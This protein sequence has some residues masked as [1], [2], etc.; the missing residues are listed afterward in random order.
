MLAC[1]AKADRYALLVGNQTYASTVGP[2]ENPINDINIVARSLEQIG[3]KSANIRKVENAD[4]VKILSEVDRYVDQLSKAG[5]DAIGFFYY[6]GHGVANQR[7]KRN[8]LIPVSVKALDAS[9]WYSAIPLDDIVRRFSEAASNAAH[10]VVF[11]ACRNLL[12][13]QTRGTKGFVPVDA[14]RGMFIAFSTDPGQTASDAG[15]QSGPYAAALAAELVKP[16]QHHLD[17]FQNVKERVI[18]NAN[19]QTP[20]ERNG[21]VRRVYLAGK[22]APAR[23]AISSK[24]TPPVSEPAIAWSVV[25]TSKN[26]QIVRTFADQYPG[27]VWA[28]FAE[29]RLSALGCPI[30]AE[31]L[32]PQRAFAIASQAFRKNDWATA[33]PYLEHGARKEHAPSM[34]MWGEVLTMGL[35]GGKDETAGLNWLEKAAAKQNSH[36]A[37]ALGFAYNDGTGTNA[38]PKKAASLFLDA[39]RTSANETEQRHYIRLL[40]AN[41]KQLSVP[42]IQTLQLELGVEVTGDFDVATRD[43]LERYSAQFANEN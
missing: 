4:R 42:T 15:Q 12:R 28:K 24:P 18:K 6:S 39:L 23:S 5:S 32:D 2:L 29:T 41:K 31:D 13:T 38:D 36:G 8:Y 3:F 1:P 40:H 43:A 30:V 35:G 16:G 14:R 17:L 10:F 7:D 33:R 21:L 19:G 37:F 26:C 20:W 11:D 27:S 34:A 22:E 9:L 25:E